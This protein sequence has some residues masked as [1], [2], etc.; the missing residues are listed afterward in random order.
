MNDPIKDIQDFL[1]AQGFQNVFYDGF[2]VF[3][4]DDQ[5][6]YN[7][8]SIESEPATSEHNLPLTELIIAIYN[9]HPNNLTVKQIS[10]Q[11]ADLL[12]GQ[13]GPLILEDENAVTFSR[14][15]CI[16]E[17]YNYSKSVNNQ[18]IYLCRFRVIYKNPNKRNP[19]SMPLDR[20]ATPT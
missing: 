10:R 2:A 16:T 11:I 8:I 6:N 1:I 12:D 19:V 14:I 17:P 15:I 9:K 4:D 7:Q 3:E 13:Y 20:I 18:N 5:K